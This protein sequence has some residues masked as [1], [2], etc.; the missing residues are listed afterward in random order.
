[1]IIRDGG[2]VEALRAEDP[3]ELMGVDSPER[4]AAAEELLEEWG[5]E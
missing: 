3:R 2:A 5:E 1:M 4:L